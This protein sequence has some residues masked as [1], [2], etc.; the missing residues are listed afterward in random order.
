M[1]N[2]FTYHIP[3][4]SPSPSNC[5]NTQAPR[6]RAIGA[7]AFVEEQLRRHA[8]VV[9]HAWVEGLC[10]VVAAAGTQVVYVAARTGTHGRIDVVD[11][12]AGVAIEALGALRVY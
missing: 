4:N 6:T 8:Q 11:S 1:C 3:A 10:A 7:L 2:A 12:W 9:G 5:S